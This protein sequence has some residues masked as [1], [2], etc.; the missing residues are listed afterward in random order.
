MPS[1]LKSLL[2]LVLLCVSAC[3]PHPV[4]G[5]KTKPA[6][7]AGPVT[8]APGFYRLPFGAL[9]LTSL[10]DGGYVT[11]ND[12]GDFGSQ[13]GPAAV[14]KLLQAA[15]APTDRIS[16]S[17]DAL[18]VR[19]PGHLVLLDTGLGPT[20]HGVLPQSLAMAG[21][22]PDQITDVLITH[23]HTDHVGG[24]VTAA[25]KPAF[26][27]AV[28]HIS[29]REWPGML[30]GASTKAIAAAVA[31]Q[32]KTFEPGQPILPG[33]TPVALYGHTPG[34]VGYEMA[35]NGQALE[36]IGDTA[37]SSIVN[38][39]EPAWRGGMD[40]DSA[41]GAA[42]RVAELARLAAR[43]ALI[44]SPHFPWPGVGRIEAKGD[45]YIWKPE[46]GG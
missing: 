43:H 8:V 31:G 7:V 21:V 20:D 16:L 32:V 5:P 33:I 22:T 4:S 46:P 25:G 17:V 2:F 15:G 28:I 19:M 9:Q 26:P 44:F 13:V 39:A 14:S 1:T 27:K 41:A 29:A 24:L 42:T 6:L 10:R 38:L 23:D 11:P 30:G 36:D 35:S 3:A 45:G 18:L 34:H 40:Q 37:H 12:G